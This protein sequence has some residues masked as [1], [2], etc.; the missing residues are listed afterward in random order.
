MLNY[1]QVED[2]LGWKE[3]RN[4]HIPFL[5]RFFMMGYFEDELLNQSLNME[6]IGL[7]NIVHHFIITFTPLFHYDSPFNLKIHTNTTYFL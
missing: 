5:P 1:R 6:P 4:I 2:G 3:T 7:D